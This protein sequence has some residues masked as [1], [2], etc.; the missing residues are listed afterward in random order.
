MALYFAMINDERQ[1]PFTLEELHDAGV[2]PETYVWCKGM[3]DWV[4]AGE[5]ADICRFYRQRLFD[6][7]HPVRKVEDPKVEEAAVMPKSNGIFGSYPFPMPNE[8][9]A[10]MSHPPVSMLMVSILMT[11]LCFPPTGFIAIYYS[12]MS[13]KAWDRSMD[14]AG[15]AS[16]QGYSEEERREF[17]RVAYD[18]ARSARMWVG[19]TFFLG[20]ILYSFVV[21]LNN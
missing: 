2:T 11:L 15:G 8:E 5:V 6:K 17:R 13:R 18:S 14:N 4:Q 9:P 19:I 7:M 21:N 16:R 3:G 12:M 10:D 1:G 20:L